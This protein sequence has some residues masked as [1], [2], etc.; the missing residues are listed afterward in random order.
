VPEIDNDGFATCPD[1][2]M[3]VNCGTVGISNLMKRH[4][5][6]KKC[7]ELKARRDKKGKDMVQGSLLAFMKPKPTL[8]RPMVAGASS[9][10]SN[11]IP[12]TANTP[13]Q[14][15]FEDMDDYGQAHLMS[16][17]SGFGP[18]NGGSQFIKKL[19]ALVKQIPETISEGSENDRLAPFSDNPRNQDVSDLEG[20][21]LWEANLNR[22]LKEVLG[23]G[24]EDR[25]DEVI[26]RGK[27]GMDG[28]VKFARYFIEER[29]VSE[30]LFEGKF[31]ALLNAL[32]KM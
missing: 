2:G 11:T 9:I 23:C 26:R 7:L 13:S 28:V 5:G 4:R 18:I 10:Q 31:T 3:R 32:E 15:D 16:L 17:E 6:T 21:E 27:N 14:W 8:V 20:D 19:E 25:M 1:C 29:G 30:G 24:N 12:A 22:F